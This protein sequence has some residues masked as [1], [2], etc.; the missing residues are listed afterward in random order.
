MKRILLI[1]VVLLSI[2]SGILLVRHRSTRIQIPREELWTVM[3]TVASLRVPAEARPAF[4]GLLQIARNHFAE[5]NNKLSVYHPASELSR[6]NTQGHL[7]PASDLTRA[8][9]HTLTQTTARTSGYFDPTLLPVI[10]LWGFSGGIPPDPL[11]T[12]AAITNALSKTGLPDFIVTPESICSSAQAAPIDPGGIAKGF[13]LDLAFDAM[14]ATF[15]ETPF[16]LNLGGEIRVQGQAEPRRPWRIGVQHPLQKGATIGVV[17]IPDS[18]AIS[19]SG[20]Y[21]RY[22]VH[23]GTRYAHIIDPATGWPVTGMAGVTVLCPNAT[24]A[25]VLSTALFV[26][27]IQNASILLRAFPDAHVL[28]IPDREPIEIHISAGMGE[29]FQPAPPYRDR[30]RRLSGRF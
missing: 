4:T 30:V 26:A 7:A 9:L 1:L 3:G 25:D 20:H 5:V 8:F 29:W 27:G 18:Y 15:P 6:L 16:L 22:F 23:E 19:T 10:Q 14:Q 13:A 24:E 12:P 21:E 2:A 11:P 17:T 28:M